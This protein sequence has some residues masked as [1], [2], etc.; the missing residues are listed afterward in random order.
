MKAAA[1]ATPRSAVG[2]A[3]LPPPPP[4]G[5]ETLVPVTTLAPGAA[6]LSAGIWVA[7][8]LGVGAEDDEAEGNGE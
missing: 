5:A 7:A 8:G 2:P 6:R 3:P 1:R 4:D